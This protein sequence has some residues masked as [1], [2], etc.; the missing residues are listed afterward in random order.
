M[1]KIVGLYVTYPEK[2]TMKKCLDL[3]LDKHYIACANAFPILSFYRW[4]GKK[5]Q[6][7]EYVCLMKT[8]SEKLHS[9]IELIKN[10]HPYDVPCIL[11]YEMKAESSYY[12]W[13][14]DCLKAPNL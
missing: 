4:N 13:L 2:N 9:C 12:T 5:T 6:D 3:L 7:E 8:S 14:K 10:L 1:E 11:Q